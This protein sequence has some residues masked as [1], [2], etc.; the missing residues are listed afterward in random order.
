MDDKEKYMRWLEQMWE[1]H[2]SITREEKRAEEVLEM[3]E[4][5]GKL[6]KRRVEV[7]YFPPW[8]PSPW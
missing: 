2:S 7:P 3:F 4:D 5:L 1:L 8:E 6:S